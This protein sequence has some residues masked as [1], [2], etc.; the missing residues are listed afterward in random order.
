MQTENKNQ[1]A[2]CGKIS[3]ALD[4]YINEYNFSRKNIYLRKDE[5]GKK[6]IIIDNSLLHTDRDQGLL[7][8]LNEILDMDAQGKP[9]ATGVL[10]TSKIFSATPALIKCLDN[11]YADH[12]DWKEGR[13]EAIGNKL[14]PDL[15]YYHR[16]ISH[17]DEGRDHLEH[18][19][20]DV[21]PYIVTSKWPALTAAQ[22]N[23]QVEFDR[24]FRTVIQEKAY[25]GK[26]VMFISASM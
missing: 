17:H 2:N 23:T 15:F 12:Y 11:Y 14:N 26:K 22:V 20:I 10:S 3:G 8:K 7:L 19:L 16:T 25:F 21:M 24:A 13:G 9:V 4:W 1:T 5:N 18:N 6:Q